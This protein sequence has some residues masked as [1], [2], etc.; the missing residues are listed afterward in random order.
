MEISW[1]GD[2]G[3]IHTRILERM[4]QVLEEDT[5]YPYLKKKAMG[6]FIIVDVFVNNNQKDAITV[7][8]NS[9]KIIDNQ[10]REF[11]HSIEGETALRMEKRS[12][13]DSTK[14][15]LTKLNPGMG[16][17]FSFVFDVPG[18]IDP[19]TSSLQATGGFA[20]S[21]VLMPLKVQKK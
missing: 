12:G 10:K 11:S 6:K 19:N 14:G 21:K 17:T 7:D 16:T 9:F 8:S 3:E 5:V 1:P 2:Y 15:F 4:K 20:G 13:G 18:N